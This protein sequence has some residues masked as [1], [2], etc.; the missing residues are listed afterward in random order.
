V[1]NWNMEDT[2]EVPKRPTKFGYCI[3]EFATQETLK[4]LIQLNLQTFK[5]R[6]LT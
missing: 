3:V 6:R 1:Q 4:Y 5:Y 2:E